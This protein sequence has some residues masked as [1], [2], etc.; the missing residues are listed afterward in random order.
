[1]VP[2]TLKKSLGQHL[3]KDKNL[4]QKMVRLSGVT[5]D[6]T[7]LE[8]GPGH[9]DLTRIIAEHARSVYAVELDERFRDILKHTEQDCPHVKVIYSDILSVRIADFAGDGK[10]T[11]MGNIP[12]NVTGD[13]LF[14][15]LG[16]RR[17]IRGAYLTM[18]KEV[19]ERLT[20]RSHSRSYGALS[21]IF[22]LYAQMKLLLILGPRVFVPPPKVD[23]AFISFVFRAGVGPEIE[24]PGL[25][26]FIKTCFRYKR[27]YLRNALQ[28]SYSI[29]E[30][31][32]MYARMDFAPSVRA[33]E[34]EPEGF[35]AMHQ[36]LKGARS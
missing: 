17:A 30:I 1:M 8:I 36:L 33:E 21:V 14:K 13:I 10:I 25:V 27:K 29:G 35:V 20:S 9:G 28:D 16:E 23:S 26:R 4:L 19:A 34:I 22:Q 24:D 5:R 6:E 12:Y 7:V 15:I 3:L 31:D 18:Q 32:D 2:G 11:V